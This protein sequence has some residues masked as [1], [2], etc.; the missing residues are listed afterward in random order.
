MTRSGSPAA[1]TIDA[2]IGTACECEP[3]FEAERLLLAREPDRVLRGL[4]AVPARRRLL[5]VRIDWPDALAAARRAARGTGVEVVTVPACYPADQLAPRLCGIPSATA[6]DARQLAA[7]AAR[8]LTIAGAVRRPRVAAVPVG[9]PVGTL[10]DTDEL[11]CVALD[12]AVRG[13]LLDPDDTIDA[14]TAGLLVL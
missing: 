14:A 3:L 4:A 7:C 11:A 8:W 2:V 13:T 5:A 12:G 1:T 6:I 10:V 9:T